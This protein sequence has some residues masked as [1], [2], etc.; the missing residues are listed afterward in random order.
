MAPSEAASCYNNRAAAY[1]MQSKFQQA[2][3]DAQAALILEPDNI[4]V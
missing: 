3:S 4:K 2:A 1:M